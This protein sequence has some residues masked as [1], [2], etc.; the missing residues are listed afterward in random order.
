MTIEIKGITEKYKELRTK[1][2]QGATGPSFL[3]RFDFKFNDEKNLNEVF[4][5]LNQKGLA[6]KAVSILDM[7]TNEWIH[8]HFLHFT[9]GTGKSAISYFEIPILSEREEQV[10]KVLDNI[11]PCVH[12]VECTTG[13]A[14]QY[15]ANMMTYEITEEELEKYNKDNKDSVKE[16]YLEFVFGVKIL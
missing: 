9:K 4:E 6:K 15:K 3:L 8:I 5:F 14:H 13:C 11:I 7:N 1:H 16:E 2:I 10:F 12:G